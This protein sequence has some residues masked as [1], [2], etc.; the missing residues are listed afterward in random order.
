MAF[1]VNPKMASPLPVV[2]A[3]GVGEATT[4]EVNLDEEVPKS[5]PPPTSLI[6]DAV[7]VH[8]RDNAIPGRTLET[9]EIVAVDFAN[10]ITFAS[11]AGAASRQ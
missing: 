1:S 6:L 5:P 9:Y 3:K 8:N 10:R 4:A 2:G 7:H 11:A